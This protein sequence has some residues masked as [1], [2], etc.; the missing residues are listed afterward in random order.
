MAS[1]SPKSLA[2][3]LQQRSDHLSMLLSQV[4]LLRLITTVIRGVLPEPLSLHCHAA[5]INGDILI[6]GCDSPTWAA[7]L[8]FLLPQVLERLKDHRQLPPFKHI[9][10]RVQ[11]I[12]KVVTQTA[13]R[14]VSMTTHSAAMIASV[15]YDT[16]DPELR[17]ALLRLSQRA[18]SVKNR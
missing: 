17:A 18:R 12:D 10:I 1:V 14:K 2:H 3:F 5:N 6:I 9:R 16:T 7:K 11:P 15:A 4:R 13:K 8:R